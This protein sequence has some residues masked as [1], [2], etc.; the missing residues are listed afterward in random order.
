MKQSILITGCSSGIGL[1]AAKTLHQKGYRVF[2]T[3]RKAQDVEHLQQLGLESVLLDLNDSHSIRAAL[4]TILEKTGGTLDAIF[5]NAGYGQGGAIDSLTR[6]MMRTQ[7]ETNVLGPMEL[8]IQLLPIMRQQGHGRII[9]NTSILGTITMP[10]Y[11]AYT[12]SKFALEAF[13]S[14][15]RQEL[16]GT[17]IFVSIIAPGPIESQFRETAY[18]RFKET[19]KQNTLP[20]HKKLE[21]FFSPKSDARPPFTLP[22]EAVVKKLIHALESRKPKAHYYVTIPAHLMAL[23]RRVLPESAMDWIVSAASKK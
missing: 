19:I 16:R 21:Q 13:S 9:Q 5:N 17:S 10:Y 14:T 23:L 1:C 20:L 22:P 3:A 2:A 4:S 8:I 7:F 11:G 18:A 12:A 15:L 6:D